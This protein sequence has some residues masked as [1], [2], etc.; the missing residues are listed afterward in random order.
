MFSPICIVC[1]LVCH[2][3]CESEVSDVVLLLYVLHRGNVVATAGGSGVHWPGG[4][5]TCQSL[6]SYCTYSSENCRPIHVVLLCMTIVASFKMCII[7]FIDR[8]LTVT[9]CYL[10]TMKCLAIFILSKQLV[11][12]I[13]FHYN[14]NIIQGGKIWALLF[15]NVDVIQRW[16]C[17]THVMVTVAS[18]SDMN[19]SVRP[20]I[21]QMA[22]L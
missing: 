9:K 8:L 13:D 4:I 11:D 2:P 19:Q 15:F 18:L 7:L 22:L 21:E 5:E 1:Q 3:K 12:M 20:F 6:S 14:S 17:Y 16:A 10:K